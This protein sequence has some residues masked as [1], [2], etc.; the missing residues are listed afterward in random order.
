MLTRGVRG[1]VRQNFLKSALRSTVTPL[2]SIDSLL[3]L[4]TAFSASAMALASAAIS[5]G[6]R[7]GSSSSARTFYSASDAGAGG[8]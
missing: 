5:S 2:E 3:P 4:S 7:A 1:P 8:V 6:V